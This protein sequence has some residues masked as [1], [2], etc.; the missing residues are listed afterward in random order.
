M[1]SFKLWIHWRYLILITLQKQFAPF[2]LDYLIKVEITRV[3][4]TSI[5]SSKLDQPIN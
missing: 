3:G 2:K 1:P 4:I 5:N